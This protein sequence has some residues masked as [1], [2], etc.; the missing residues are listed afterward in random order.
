MSN[1]Y[2]D[3]SYDL[4]ARREARAYG[5]DYDDPN[6]MYLPEGAWRLNESVLDQHVCA[7]VCE[8][9]KMTPDAWGQLT[10]AQ[11]VPWIEQ[12]IVAERSKGAMPQD[13][14]PASM[15][16]QDAR[17]RMERL[18]SQG[19][20]FTS[21]GNLASQF[22]CSSGTINKAI[23]KTPSLHEW[24]GVGREGKSAPKAQSITDVTTDRTAQSREPNPED[25][26]A[27][28]EYIEEADA[29]G[30]GWFQGLSYEKQLEVVNDPD[31]HQKIL[32]RKP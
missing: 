17:D 14:A 9:G 29:E 3:L 6:A 5:I 22:D 24:A 15:T 2:D 7:A 8:L 19:E 13:D 21:Q 28:R 11:K 10:L 32:G 30:R 16:W 4:L 12:A 25:D 31:K 23:H 18:R 26:A 1:Q 20:P 27:I